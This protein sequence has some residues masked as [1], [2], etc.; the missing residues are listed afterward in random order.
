MVGKRYGLK[1][2]FEKKNWIIETENAIETLGLYNHLG[3]CQKNFKED[4]ASL[5]YVLE[6]N[7]S[8]IFENSSIK[9]FED[10]VFEILKN[11][12]SSLNKINFDEEANLENINGLIQMVSI[13]YFS[14]YTNENQKYIFV[15]KNLV[16]K[17]INCIKK[18]V[19]N[20]TD[21]LH[22]HQILVTLIRTS[23]IL[24]QFNVVDFRI[25]MSLK[26][27]LNLYKKHF[28]N[29]ITTILINILNQ[30]FGETEVKSLESISNFQIFL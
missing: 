17:L 3:F 13:G 11:K 10:T 21:S 15:I 5:Y 1:L 14:S 22:I 2:S 16:K 6:C 23:V 27:L 19:E 29:K 24:Q 18:R 26:M 12:Q 20:S 8:V 28:F 7:V 9:F 30:L 4:C 25:D